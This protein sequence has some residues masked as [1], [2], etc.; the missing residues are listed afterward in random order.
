[1]TD[2]GTKALLSFTLGPVQP[3]IAA[4]RSV[5]DLWTGSW[6]LSW[7]TWH[8]AAPLRRR[9]NV[10]FVTPADFPDEEPF[11]PGLPNTFVAAVGSD[12]DAARTLAGECKAAC[13]KAWQTL[14]GSVRGRLDDAG[15]RSLSGEWDARFGRQCEDYFDLRT[16][17]LPADVPAGRVREL[18]GARGEGLTDVSARLELLGALQ[19]VGKMI[20][21][22]PE[23]TRPSELVPGKCSLLGTFEHVGPADRAE[24][25]EFWKA[26]AEQVRINGC[27]TRKSER[28][29]AVSLVKRFAPAVTKNLVERL[30]LDDDDRSGASLRFEDTAC[31]AAAEW[32]DKDGR[33]GIRAHC[34]RHGGQW[35]HW[36]KPDA[37]K[38]EEAVPGRLFD[39]LRRQRADDPVPA[40]YAVLMMDGDQM[41][42]KL[43]ACKDAA[44][45]GRISR[46]L[47]AFSGKVGEAIRKAFGT[48]IYAGGDDVLALLPVTQVVGS[49]QSLQTAYQESLK[50]SLRDLTGHNAGISAG[51][52][53]VHY[54]EDLRFAL[55]AAR[56]AERA[57]KNSGRNRLALAVCR[58]SGEHTAATMPWTMCGAFG[59]LVEQFVDG[60]S[61]RWTYK[62]RAESGTLIGLD[63]DAVVAETRRLLKRIE[64]PDDLKKRFGELAAGLLL[65][66]RSDFDRRHPKADAAAAVEAV[67]TNFL[68]LCQSASFLARG[69][70]A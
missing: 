35:L 16:H 64:A 4:A 29:C 41:G 19:A 15:V 57:A 31:V 46:A 9:G 45:R 55:Q 33:A 32:L 67:L 18:L 58:R 65:S 68:T 44:A 7:L 25:A 60:V 63:W 12:A 13:R 11:E 3:F 6:L 8:A 42:E 24:S 21:H 28:L 47:E 59:E 70:D 49:A 39:E 54:K 43:R 69:R 20:R 48:P 26:F 14:W 2:Q 1:M 22:F 61:D 53:V 17:V 40:Y 50:D 27:R 30:R 62:L 51:I 34:G 37:G 10:E 36:S 56:D 5:R 66:C 52:A 23:D 38:D